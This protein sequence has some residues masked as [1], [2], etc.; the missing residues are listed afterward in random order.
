MTYKCLGTQHL[1]DIY[2]SRFGMLQCEPPHNLSPFILCFENSSGSVICL[3]ACFHAEWIASLMSAL[4][5]GNAS[6]PHVAVRA[7][8][9]ARESIFYL[10]GLLSFKKYVNS[11]LVWNFTAGLSSPSLWV[12]NL[13]LCWLRLNS[14]FR[15]CY[16]FQ[17]D[18]SVCQVP[19]A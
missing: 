17:Q 2:R 19:A 15:N 6:S 3:L 14:M 18:N 11:F 1:K 8:A 9:E 4:I 12:Y 7:F 16:I 13:P 10:P 5:R